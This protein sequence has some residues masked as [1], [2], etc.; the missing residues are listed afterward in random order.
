MRELPFPIRSVLHSR[1]EQAL[2][3]APARTLLTC[4]AYQMLFH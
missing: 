3:D 1:T 4:C 2:N